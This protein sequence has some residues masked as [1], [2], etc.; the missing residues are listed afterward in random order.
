MIIRNLLSKTHNIKKHHLCGVDTVPVN[1]LVIGRINLN[2]IIYNKNTTIFKNQ[3]INSEHVIELQRIG[4]PFIQV[5]SKQLGEICFVNNN[6]G[7]VE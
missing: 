5:L 3:T 4:H 1:N 7:M 2:S 6:L